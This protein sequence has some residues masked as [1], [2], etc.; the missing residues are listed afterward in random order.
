M[1]TTLQLMVDGLAMGMVYV[2]MASG[3]NL[4]M[5]V[6][7]ILFIAF[8]QFYVL[9]AFITWYVTISGGQNF[10]LGVLAGT[11]ASGLLGALVYVAVF[12]KIQFSESQFLTNIIAG[13]GLM[14]ILGQVALMLFG[15]ETRVS[16]RVFP[17]SSTWPASQCPGTRSWSSPSA[18]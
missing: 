10:F 3:F 5:S 4:I 8:G 9:G 15:T 11:V 18:C 13:F 1:H 17:A 2:F 7:R 6:P 12:R 14:M 16:P